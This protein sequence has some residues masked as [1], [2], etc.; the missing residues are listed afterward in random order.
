MSQKSDRDLYHELSYYTLTHPSPAFI[1]QFIVDAFAAQ[2][3]TAKT[4]PI[5]LAFALVGLYLHVEK[6]CT[7]RQVQQVHVRLAR[8]RRSWPTFKLPKDR[9]DVTVADVLGAP[10]GPLRDAAIER[11]CRS[12]WNAYRENHEQ[13]AKLLEEDAR[14]VAGPS[15]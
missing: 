10:P 7:G 1:H 4:K 2:Q 11:W 15:R 14:E 3:A 13:V 5:R 9:G 6:G 8:R 12:V